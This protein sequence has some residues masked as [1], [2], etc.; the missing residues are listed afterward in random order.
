MVEDEA[1]NGGRDVVDGSKRGDT[2]HSSEDDGHI[3]VLEPGVRIPAIEGPGDDG[4]DSAH[5][6]EVE[7]RSVQTPGAEYV[8]GGNDTPDDGG[9]GGHD[10]VWAGEAVRLRDI[11]HPLDITKHPVH[12]A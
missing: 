12:Y 3:D 4:R 8:G 5:D 7:Q 10:C 1:H 9:G 2:D 6:E 11:T